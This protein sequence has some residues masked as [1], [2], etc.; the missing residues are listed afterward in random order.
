ML[1]TR[2]RQ[3]RARSSLQ[4]LEA[5]AVDEYDA[6]DDDGGDC[7]RLGGATPIGESTPAVPWSF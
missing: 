7:M 3:C 2:G 4:R 5:V 6:G 1:G